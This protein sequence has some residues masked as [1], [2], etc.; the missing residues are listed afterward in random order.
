M[1]RAIC[2]VILLAVLLTACGVPDPLETPSPPPPVDTATPDVTA[3]ASAT[4]TLTPTLTPTRTQTP[5]VTLTPTPTPTIPPVGAGTPLPPLGGPII[6]L[7]MLRVRQM[8]QWGRGR[9]DGLAWSPGGGLIA[10]TTP[11]GVYLYGTQT[12]TSPLLLDAGGAASLPVFSPDGRF[13][14]VDTAPSGSGAG[15]NVPERRVQVW[16]ISGTEISLRATLATSQPALAITFNPN[17]EL[18]AVVSVR[19]GAQY[20]RWELANQR[21][22]QAMN[23]ISGETAAAAAISPD[24]RVVATRGDTGPV[25]LWRLANGINIASSQVNERAGMLAFSPDSSLLAVT[26]PDFTGDFTNQN[27]IRV[28]RVPTG[29][30]GLTD[31]AYSLTNPETAVGSDETLISLAWSTDGVYIAAGSADQRVSVWRAGASAP[32]YRTFQTSTLPRHLSFAPPS[33]PGSPRLASGALEVWDLNVAPPGNARAVFTN[34]FLPGLYDMEFSPS[35]SVLA[36][37]SHSLIEM[38]STADGT[39]TLAITNMRGPVRAISY[40]PDGTQLVA[41]CQDGTTRLYRTSDGLFTALLGEPTVPML[42]AD[43]SSNG[44]WIIS[45][46]EDMLVRVYRATDGALMYAIREPFVGYKLLF[47]PNSNQFASLTTSGVRLRGFFSTLERVDLDW[48]AWIGGVGLSDIAYS[49][50]Q[51]YLALVGNNVVRVIDPIFREEVYNIFEPS[52]ALPWSV[53]F[54]PDNAFMAVG[55]SDG[56]IRL[57]WAQDGRLM[58]SWQ[59]HPDSVTRLTFRRDGRLL[60]SL[61]SEGTLRLWGVDE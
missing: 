56:R 61:G 11:L 27:Q 36:L 21:Q 45:S 54:S 28:W 47:S 53:A 20:Q 33:F 59:A 48:E 16:E 31:L 41:A 19:G 55:Y 24:F 60:A 38:R 39:R 37:A 46:G 8:A 25:R 29:S 6:E 3:T 40:S 51:E 4:V 32:A 12:F 42:A 1:N 18:V 26:Y 52:G 2:L 43:F 13:L 7:T 17:G 44:F 57:F 10:V 50:G 35:G 34:D 30:G 15:L 22:V 9:V 5:T 49:P 23:L 58:H 14:A